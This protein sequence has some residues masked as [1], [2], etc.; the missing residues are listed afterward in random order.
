[1]TGTRTAAGVYL[2][3]GVTQ[4]PRLLMDF[5]HAPWS[6]AD[7]GRFRAEPSDCYVAR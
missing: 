3:E 1:M 2:V 6:G 5:G 4:R 7:P